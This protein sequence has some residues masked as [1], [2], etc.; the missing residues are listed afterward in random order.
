MASLPGHG[1]DTACGVGSWRAGR[2]P[3][4]RGAA[5]PSCQAC[6]HLQVAKQAD[7]TRAS[8]APH[9]LQVLWSLRG[10]RS[11]TAGSTARG[12][13]GGDVSVAARSRHRRKGL[14]IVPSTVQALLLAE[15]AR[16]LAWTKVPFS[17]SCLRKLPELWL[18]TSSRC[19]VALQAKTQR[20]TTLVKKSR[21]SAGWPGKNSCKPSTL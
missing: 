4:A 7:A 14:R 21:P 19:R 2:L 8:L 5:G 1:G 13:P 3:G 6:A 20:R 9:G 11:Q 17:P 16:V 15:A 10:T 12:D 18:A